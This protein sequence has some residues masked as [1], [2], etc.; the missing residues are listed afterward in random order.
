MK[1]PLIATMLLALAVSTTASAATIKDKDRKLAHRLVEMYYLCRRYGWPEGDD[2]HMEA[3]C[4]TYE[5]L[6]KVLKL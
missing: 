5:V 3:T 1:S 6:E 2:G 4:D